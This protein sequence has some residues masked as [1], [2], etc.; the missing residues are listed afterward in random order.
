[1]PNTIYLFDLSIPLNPEIF[2]RDIFFIEKNIRLEIER[3]LTDQFETIVQ[4]LYQLDI[5]EKKVRNCFGPTHSTESIAAELTKLIIESIQ[6][7]IEWRKRF[8]SNNLLD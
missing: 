6:Q 3:R 2:S 8:Q 4:A 7:K 1:M 5:S